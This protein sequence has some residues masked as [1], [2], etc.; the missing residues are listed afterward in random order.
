MIVE[1]SFFDIELSNGAITKSGMAYWKNEE[2]AF[3][4]LYGVKYFKK[5]RALRMCF[6][7][8]LRQK[9]HTGASRMTCR[10]KDK[11]R[12]ENDFEIPMDCCKNTLEQAGVASSLVE[13]PLRCEWVNT[14]GNH[15][16]YHQAA[17]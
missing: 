13:A 9:F 17:S 4:F 8:Q 6:Y 14:P 15:F 10:T 1:H 12:S 7:Y 3:K 11:S 5:L 2:H 16:W